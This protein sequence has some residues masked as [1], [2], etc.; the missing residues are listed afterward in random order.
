MQFTAA[1]DCRG[2]YLGQ[3][4]AKK[5]DLAAYHALLDIGGGSGVYSCSLVT[6]HPHLHAT[7]LEKP[8]VDRIAREAVTRRG[9]ADK[10]DVIA[11]D[12]FAAPLPA[13]FDAHLIS[14]VLHD[15]DERVVRA[16]LA[17]SAAALPADGLL[18]I[19]DAHI[20]AQKS[21]PLPVAQYSV[22]LMHSTEGKCYSLGEMRRFFEDV[23][24]DWLEHQPTAADRSVILARKR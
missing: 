6:H 14:N 19:H 4:L 1:M 2:V 20:N 10:V 23:G 24:F 11:G 21:G 12:M 22:L 9:C 16:L 13:G 8:P 3:A 5:L 17:K 7:V 15:W 18:I